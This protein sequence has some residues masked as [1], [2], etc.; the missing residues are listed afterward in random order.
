MR[1]TSTARLGAPASRAR[2]RVAPAPAARRGAR[3]RAGPLRRGQGLLRPPRPR[4]RRSLPAPA[5]GDVTS[6]EVLER[7]ADRLV[8]RVGYVYNDGAAPFRGDCRGFG[9]RVLHRG[10]QPGRPRGGRDDRHAA[11]EGRPH[12]ADRRQWRLVGPR[13]RPLLGL[14]ALAPA[15]RTRTR[16]GR[17]AASPACCS[18]SSSTTS[19]TRSRRAAPARRRCS[20]A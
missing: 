18:R 19:S 2:A 20:K 16:P 3:G 9:S 15:I 5:L 10:A 8:V 4:R 13:S 12:R 7:A 1:S 17:S 6:S 14:L 11:S